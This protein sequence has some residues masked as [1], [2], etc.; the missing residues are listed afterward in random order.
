MRKGEIS[1]KKNAVHRQSTAWI[2][3]LAFILVPLR[4]AYPHD[5]WLLPEQFI[6]SQGDVLTVHQL[7][8]HELKVEVELPVLR[9]ITPSF[10]LLNPDGLVDL[11]G[12]LPDIRTQAEVK[13]VLQRKLDFEGLAL[14]TME[15]AFIDA[16]FPAEEFSEYFE[17]EEFKVNHPY[18][19]VGQCSSERERYARSLKSLIQVGASAEGEL[20]QQVI[21]HKL[22]ILLL[23]N[24]YLLDAGDKLE[25]RVLFEG[26]PLPERLVIA[27]NGDGEQLVSMSKVHTDS[28]GIAA[29][30][31]VGPGFW[32]IRL[33]HLLPC[34]DQ[35]DG[36]CGDVD[37]ESYWA[38]YSF[39]LDL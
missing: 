9:T 24:P 5:I 10:S 36:D 15:H 16:E 30:K 13:P 2:F 4:V 22:E 14:F 21:G 34:S 18:H 11:L 31:L 32:L 1:M 37:W 33:V 28:D 7:A 39:W 27:L 19:Q 38:S 26:E 20:Y 17:Y 35:Y 6:L 8:G 12:E 25:V 29:F 23:Q 3:T